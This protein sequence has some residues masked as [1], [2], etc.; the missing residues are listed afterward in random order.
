MMEARDGFA[1]ALVGEGLDHRVPGGHPEAIDRLRRVLAAAREAPFDQVM[2]LDYQP[3]DRQDLVAVHAPYYVDALFAIEA[4]DEV[5]PLDPDTWMS[6]GSLDAARAVSGA[7][8]AAVDWALAR[9]GRRAF[10]A[11]RPPGHHAERGRAMGFCLLNHVAIAAAHARHGHGVERVAIVDFD[12]HHGN[13]T[14]Q[15]AQDDA[16]ITFISVHQGGIYP[17]TGAAEEAGPF[18]NVINRPMPA[19]TRSHGWRSVWEGELFDRLRQ[20]RPQLLLISAGF[21]AHEADPLAGLEL[22]T[23]DYAWITKGLRAVLAEEAPVSLVSFLEG[24]YDLDAL[25]DSVKAHWL[26]LM[27]E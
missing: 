24:G 8:L 13:G 27:S 14:D 19:G 4:G 9:P 1:F 26:E 7:G 18:G 15:Y 21:D 20:A 22:T 25:A 16:G 6:A 5:V 17:G 2:R 11:G 10:V 3:A 12:V 23:K